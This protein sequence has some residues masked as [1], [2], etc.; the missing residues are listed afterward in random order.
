MHLCMQDDQIDQ[1]LMGL[2]PADM[3]KLL[4]FIG[5]YNKMFLV[6]NDLVHQLGLHLL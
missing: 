6:V 4:Q 2:A 5:K 1:K 3:A